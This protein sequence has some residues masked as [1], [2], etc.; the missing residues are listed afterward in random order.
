MEPI[1]T[2]I[3]PVPGNIALLAIPIVGLPPKA[4]PLVTEISSASPAIDTGEI[5]VP[6]ATASNPEPAV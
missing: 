3:E 5:V 2:V 6:V 1:G 4:L